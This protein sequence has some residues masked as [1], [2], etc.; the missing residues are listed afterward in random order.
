M[1]LVEFDDKTYLA[2]IAVL[3]DGATRIDSGERPGTSIAPDEVVAKL[4]ALPKTG[5]RRRRRA[6]RSYCTRTMN[7]SWFAARSP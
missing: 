4:R 7:G 1:P 3:R 2:Q 6:V 5:P